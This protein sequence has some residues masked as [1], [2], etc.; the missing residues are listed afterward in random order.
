M[1]VFTG[2]VIELIGRPYATRVSSVYFSS[3][4]LGITV[5]PAIAFLLPDEFWYQVAAQS[6]PFLFPVGI[7]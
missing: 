6:V 7:M 2:A 5:Q 3:V 4:A 1:C